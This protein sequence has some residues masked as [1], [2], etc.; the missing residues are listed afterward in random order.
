MRRD[1]MMTISRLYPSTA[2]PLMS[3]GTVLG[4]VA[5]AAFGLTL[6]LTRIAVP[7]FGPFGVTALRGA[8][9]GIVALGILL[10]ERAPLPAAP[11]RRELAVVALGTVVGFPLF[12]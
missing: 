6:A 2:T 11:E 10:A 3:E 5:V 1:E 4:L 12:A 9:G 7:S 8:L